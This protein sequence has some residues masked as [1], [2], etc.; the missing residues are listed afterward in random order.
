MCLLLFG[1]EVFLKDSFVEG[2]ILTV[3]LFREEA[4]GIKGMGGGDN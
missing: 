4:L 2:L 3:A 1:S